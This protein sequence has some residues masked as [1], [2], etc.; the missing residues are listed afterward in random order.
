MAHRGEQGAPAAEQRGHGGEHGA[1]N[2]K[3]ETRDNQ[4]VTPAQDKASKVRA[5]I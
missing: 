5:G 3:G 4:Q 1:P 2:M